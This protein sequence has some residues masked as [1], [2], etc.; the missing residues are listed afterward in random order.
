MSDTRKSNPRRKVPEPDQRALTKIQAERLGE[1]ASVA[2]DTLVGKKI[3]AINELLKFTIDPELLF[4]RR[5][6]GRVVKEDPATGEL[7][8]VPNA[9][10]HV[11]DTDCSFLGLFPSGPWG[12]LFP[13]ICRRE[14]IAT[15][16]TDEC[17][18]FCVLI[19]RWEIDYILRWKRV[20]L[21]VPDLLRA[22]LRDVL[23]IDPHPPIIRD[24]RPQPDPAPFRI[25]LDR[26]REVAGV[27]AAARL[28]QFQTERTFASPLVEVE[29]ALATPTLPLPPPKLPGIGNLPRKEMVEALAER[30]PVERALLE[31]ID[32]D[33][34]V[35]PFWK[36]HDVFYP[37]F[38]PLFDV[39]DITFRVTQDVDG[40]GDEEVIYS[41]GY[42]EVRWNAGP[43]P[44]VE[45][46]ASG[47][48]LAT[49]ICDGPDIDPGACS[50]PTIVT[51]GLMPLEASYHDSTTG[52]ALRPNKPRPG[53]FSDSPQTSPAQAP[54]LGT[55]QLHGCHRFDG[56]QFYRF[57]YAY[58][59]ASPVPFVGLDW[60]TPLL[61][62]S[63]N[64]HV[65]PD[66]NGWYDILP[67]GNLIFPHWLL[68][69][70]RGCHLRQRA[71]P[72]DPL[73]LPR[74]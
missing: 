48:A 18:N 70:V 34:Y 9:T 17:G 51:V 49:P 60:Y 15:A 46:R 3:A 61:D 50:E 14:E 41:E 10:V 26:V 43:I 2:P 58:A 25:D 65:V 7:W 35:G 68:N 23:P 19:P 66:P 16:I 67:P 20:R 71:S 69:C 59:A 72:H 30:L 33:R 22:R 40:D 29:G 73:G 4:F 74:P 13:S 47:N 54:Y 6:C 37:E 63:G 39:P 32:F 27:Q 11:E 44:D 64:L 56:A 12:W 1:L 62:G 24:P 38:V 57:V 8:G 36:C 53:G 55:L 42:F 31:R 21:C 28:E 45:L 5:V 52:Y